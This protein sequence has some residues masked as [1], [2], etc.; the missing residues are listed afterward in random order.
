MDSNPR[1]HGYGDSPDPKEPPVELKKV[2]EP[3][4]HCGG[5]TLHMIE[6]VLKTRQVSKPFKDQEMLWASTLVALPVLLLRQ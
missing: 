4:P 1:D 2:E 5:Q 6:A 3:C